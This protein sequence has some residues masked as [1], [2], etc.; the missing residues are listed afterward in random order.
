M[1]VVFLQDVPN[2]A[3]ARDVKEVAAG[4]ARNYLFPRNLAAPATTAELQKL[5]SRLRADARQRDRLEQEAQAFAEELANTK[6]SFTARTG[7]EE[8]LYGSITS[9][10][11]ATE[12]KKIT[13]HEIDKRDIE[14]EAPI[15]E[16]GS[17]QV[18]I[19]LTKSLTAKVNILVEPEQSSTDTGGET[20]K[21]GKAK[22]EQQVEQE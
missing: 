22:D 10:D 9:A 11:I 3:S 21:K 20:R 19:K 6:I 18:S 1:K 15:R 12:I 16:L 7:G 4:F 5:E 8:R 14:I 17:H 13:G 2:V